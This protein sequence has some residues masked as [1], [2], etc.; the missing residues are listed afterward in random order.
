[1]DYNELVFEKSETFQI[2]KTD[3]SNGKANSL[4]TIVPYVMSKA[5]DFIAI[6][7]EGLWICQ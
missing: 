4:A 6:I 3:N 1:M 5:F 7:P 2:K